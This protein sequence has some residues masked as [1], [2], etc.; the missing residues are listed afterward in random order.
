MECL[1]HVISVA[2]KAGVFNVQSKDGLLDTLI[3]RAK[4]NKAITWTNKSQKGTLTLIQAQKHCKL[5]NFCLL[6]PSKT[7][8]PD[9]LQSFKILIIN[10]DSIYYI[11]GPMPVVINDIKTR[12]PSDEDWEVVHVVVHTMK[13]VVTIV[14]RIN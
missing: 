8:F 5:A 6:A 1:A 7:S 13:E 14:H 12:K 10:K 9:I 3:T 4:I 2:Y 11:Y